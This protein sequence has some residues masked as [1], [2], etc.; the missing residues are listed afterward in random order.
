MSMF[1]SI[2]GAVTRT[3]NTVGALAGAA[4]KSVSIGTTWID[5]QSIVINASG[6]ENAILALTLNLELVQKELE[7]NAKRQVLFDA[8]SVLFMSD[9]EKA[10][11]AAK[12]R[13]Q[14]AASDAAPRTTAKIGRAA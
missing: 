10:A 7:G 2:F 12:L 13:Q 4:E 8:C 3:A 11:H 14:E 6:K 1:R 9:D 5:Q